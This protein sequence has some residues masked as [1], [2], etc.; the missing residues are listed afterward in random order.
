MA[1]WVLDDVNVVV[2]A[3]SGHTASTVIELVQTTIEKLVV[4]ASA[5]VASV[6]VIFH[7]D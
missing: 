7:I 5:S 6:T 3:A 4:S 1:Y 2:P